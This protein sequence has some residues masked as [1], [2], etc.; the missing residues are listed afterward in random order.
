MAVPK[1]R[2]N[3]SDLA[4]IQRIRKNYN[5][6]ITRLE[7]KGFEAALLPQR[8]TSKSI[9]QEYGTRKDLKNFMKQAETFVRRGSEKIVEYKG[10]KIPAF[11]KQRVIRM[12]QSVQQQKTAKRKKL[13]AEAGNLSNAT[14]TE[15]R[16][17]NTQKIR[18]AKEWDKYVKSLEAQFSKQ[19]QA[20]NAEVYKTQYLKNVKNILGEAGNDLYDFIEKQDAQKIAS[21]Y[22]FDDVLS[23]KFT[24]DPIKPKEIANAALSRWKDYLK[25]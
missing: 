23:I 14:E 20:I 2:W 5:A 8:V 9:M 3:Q 19:Q 18:T 1:I 17:L 25:S 12:Q 15:I 21:G 13:S 10:H 11:E 16:P 6:K 24:S 7:K 22:E 4:E